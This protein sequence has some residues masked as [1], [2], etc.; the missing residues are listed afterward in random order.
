MKFR[1]LADADYSIYEAKIPARSAAE[2]FASTDFSNAVPATNSF[3]VYDL[4]TA[5]WYLMNS[6][7]AGSVPGCTVIIMR[8]SAE[9]GDQILWRA[10]F[11]T[12]SRSTD[13]VR[14]KESRNRTAQRSMVTSIT[15]TFDRPI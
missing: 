15:V 3:R 6:N 7:S 9:E 10:R 1:A 12:T 11:G 4:A 14:L 13:G 2:C 5:V 8:S